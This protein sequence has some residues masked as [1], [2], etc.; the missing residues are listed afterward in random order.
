MIDGNPNVSDPRDP[1]DRPDERGPGGGR[2][3][4]RR[5][6]S[7]RPQTNQGLVAIAIVSLAALVLGGA[8]LFLTLTRPAPV[9]G[10]NCRS[11]AWA[12]LPTSDVLPDGWTI[13][14]SGFYTDGYG[15][16]LSG[17]TASGQTTAP[18]INVR[19]SCYGAD[20]HEAVTRSH[21]N[22]L[23]QGGTDVTFA[24]IGDETVATQDAAGSTTSV[25]IRRGSL[26]ASVAATQAVDP[27]DLEDAASAIDDAMVGAEAGAASAS[28][29]PSDA[30][31]SDEPIGTDE[32][33]PTESHV[34]P[35][36]E[37]LLPT[38]IDAAPLSIESTTGTT[39]LGD[40]EAS[41][42][43][44]QSLSSVGKTGDDLLVAEAF[45]P[46][47]TVDVDVIAFEVKG[48]KGADL[49]QFVLKSWLTAAGSGVS[50]STSTIAGRSVTAIDYGDEGSKDYVYESG[51]AV[52]SLT[53]SDPTVVAKVVAGTK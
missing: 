5:P 49:R 14:A 21:A 30:L 35:E 12:S 53:T 11:I 7:E 24:D 6:T 27:T 16:A 1:R 17:P 46:S 25:Y 36:L 41:Q 28:G 43:L 3:R 19:V 18:A 39:A 23:A 26:V 10:D 52:I 15:A 9:T 29:A 2:R 31:A 38:T 47:D 44:L 42:D 50:T 22:D 4:R 40:D 20:S 34:A 37:A 32:P 33:S 13:T 48:V 8:A 45:D 51:D